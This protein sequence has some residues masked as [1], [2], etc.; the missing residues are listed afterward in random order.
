MIETIRYYDIQILGWIHE[1]GQLNVLDMLLP[2]LRNP[3]FWAPLYMFMLAWMLINWRMKGFWWCVYLLMV[4][5]LCDYTAA[6]IIKPWVHRI[7]PCNDD[8]LPIMIRH[9]VKCGSGFSFPSAHAANHVGI[10]FFIYL[11]LRHFGGWIKW[12]VGIWAFAVC[13]AQVY[14]AVHFPSD[15]LAG[16]ILGLGMGGL[17]A[18]FF[19]KRKP[20]SDFSAPEKK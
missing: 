6:S 11:T 10:S 9:I 7:R 20:Y 3:Y 14:V 1:N 18:Y 17:V 12:A 19:N 2:L 16:A 4:F 8:S 13:Y 15:I 5:A